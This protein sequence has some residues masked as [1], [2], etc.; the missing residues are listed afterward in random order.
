M[1]DVAERAGVGVGTVYRHFPTKDALLGALVA[2][3]FGEF[4]GEAERALADEDAEPFE[5][6]AERAAPQRRAHGRRRRRARRDDQRRRRRSWLAAEPARALLLA[7]MAQLI[8]RAQ[9]AGTMRPDVSADDVPQLDVR[10]LRGDGR[11][12]LRLRLAPP[13]RAADRRPA[14][15]LSRSSAPPDGRPERSGP[16][17]PVATLARPSAGAGLS[18]REEHRTDAAKRSEDHEPPCPH[19]GRAD[20]ARRARL[21]HLLPAAQRAHHLPGDARWTTRSPT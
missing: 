12:R 18:H 19:G 11:G 13:R 1:D 10:P 5:V 3:R 21:R 9:A 7:L 6:F 2:E 14:R 16:A 15:P 17:R 20:V 8:A 4:C